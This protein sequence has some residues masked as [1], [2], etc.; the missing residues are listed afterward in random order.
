MLPQPIGL[1]LHL[2]TPST[3]SSE[4]SNKF[5]CGI[6]WNKIGEDESFFKEPKNLKEDACLHRKSQE[7]ENM[8]L[9]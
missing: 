3:T 2:Q 4:Y 6:H 9:M 7:T 8:H 5:F 1:Q